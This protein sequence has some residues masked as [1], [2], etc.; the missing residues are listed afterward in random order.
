[1]DLVGSLLSIATLG[2]LDAFVHASN[3]ASVVAAAVVAA[4]GAVLALRCG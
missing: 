4:L 2:A 1:M 3:V